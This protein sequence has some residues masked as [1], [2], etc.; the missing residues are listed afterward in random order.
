MSSSDTAGIS[1]PWST[2]TL[3]ANEDCPGRNLSLSLSAAKL[4]P[5]FRPE[6][7][8]PHKAQAQKCRGLSTVELCYMTWVNGLS[9]LLSLLS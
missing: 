7:D 5:L 8:K 3:G 6:W 2:A 1:Q 9:W 4:G